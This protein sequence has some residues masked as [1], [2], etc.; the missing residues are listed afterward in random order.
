M[1]QVF[2]KYN[3]AIAILYLPFYLFCFFGLERRNTTNYQVVESALDQ[4]IP[5]CE[6]FVIPYFLWFAYIATTFGYFFFTN[7]QEFIRLCIFLFTGMTICLGIYYIWP[8]GQNLRPDLASLGR[9]NIF[10]RLLAGLYNTDTHTNVCP[11]IHT[12]NSVGAC[13]A[14]FKSKSLSA[15]P[16]LRWSAL[17]LTVS[18]CLSTVFLKQHSILD[19]FWA[20]VLSVP[21]Y[22]LAYMPKLAQIPKQIREP[23]TTH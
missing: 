2:K 6:W 16:W 5:F 3:H 13:I 14:I 8:N 22:L 11:S 23:G 1:K 4:Y 12:F 19:V 18:I 20:L 21:M 7:K 17:I 15:K 10:L 9:D